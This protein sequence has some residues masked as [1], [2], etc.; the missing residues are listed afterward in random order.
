[1]LAWFASLLL[2]LAPMYRAAGAE[3]AWNTNLSKGPVSFFDTFLFDDSVFK[4]I[5][6]ERLAEELRRL[7]KDN[8]EVLE[9]ILGRK[10]F[11][12]QSA[13]LLSRT[14]TP[15]L[16]AAIQNSNI[17][18]VEVFVDFGAVIGGKE[19]RTA[20]L[21]FE[22]D[23][24][25]FFVNNIIQSGRKLGDNALLWI[26]YKDPR[27]I[28]FLRVLL[29]RVQLNPQV[30]TGRKTQPIH[31]AAAAH[32]IEALKT[33]TAAGA[34]INA[35]DSQGWTAAHWA[36]SSLYKQPKDFNQNKSLI[37][38]VFQTLDSLGIDWDL[39][40]NIDHTALE[41]AI[42]K[43]P[44][45]AVSALVKDIQVNLNSVNKNE[46]N[47]L[48]FAVRND[49]IQRANMLL[50]SGANANQMNSSGES[51]LLVIIREMGFHVSTRN[52]SKGKSKLI[53]R[54]IKLSFRLNVQDSQGRTAAHWAVINNIP[55]GIFKKLL[56]RQAINTRDY[57]YRT[58]LDYLPETRRNVLRRGGSEILEEAVCRQNFARRR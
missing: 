4:L 16:Q 34:D 21:N 8:P 48:F 36:V 45:Y 14:I 17:G 27:S 19:V 33:L 12:P 38:S 11:N 20:I 50:D 43:A 1:M 30:Q 13:G 56:K 41:D 39:R 37:L 55:F 28:K 31:R 5:T 3:D 44:E 24:F 7:Q 51:I 53:D 35:Q 26:N 40:N 52:V 10:S 22:F 25:N 29:D 32:N 15:P 23:I 46:E 6:P 49:R 2:F 47:S 57:T 42:L 9:Q 54:L 18:F 58:P